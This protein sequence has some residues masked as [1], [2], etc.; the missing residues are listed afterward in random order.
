MV[1]FTGCIATPLAKRERRGVWLRKTT[2]CMYV[3]SMAG[4]DVQLVSSD[5]ADI[6]EVR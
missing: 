6:P 2:L 1:W 4:Q 3:Y 5:E